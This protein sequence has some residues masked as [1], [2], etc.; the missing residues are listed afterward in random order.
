[1]AEVTGWRAVA[2]RLRES[3]GPAT[4]EQLTLAELLGVGLD[5]STPTPVAATTL[6]AALYQ[7][8]GEHTPRPVSEAQREYLAALAE[9]L[10]R[11]APKPENSLVASGWIEY[12]VVSGRIRALMS[13]RPEPGDTMR[14]AQ[15][16]NRVFELSSVG[17]EG[18]L[19]FRGRQL[20]WP[21]Q[22]VRLEG[23]GS[24]PR[25][26]Q[27][28][29]AARNQAA[30]TAPLTGPSVDGMAELRR[31]K[32][33]AAPDA[34][35]V[36]LLQGAVS[37][38]STEAPV[39]EVLTRYPGLLATAVLSKSHAQYVLPKLRLGGAY[40]T[41]F[42]VADADS[43]GLRWIFVELESPAAPVTLASQRDFSKAA[44]TGIAQIRE[45]R[46]WLQANMAM[47]RAKR[48]DQGLGLTGIRPGADGLVVVGRRHELKEQASSLRRSLAETERIHVR[49]YD[50]L[51]EQ[52]ARKPG[53]QPGTP[54]QRDDD[55]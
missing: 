6:R 49:T 39:Q 7:P 53:G 21:D 45:W 22:V 51:V 25:A 24:S 1:M 18:R 43:G 14:L 12:F 31:F 40:V 23:P 54:W 38:A 44:R 19:H 30:E 13:L 35:A 8:I 41:D 26:D 36:A 9:A 42:L 3:I 47:A 5:S 16:P 48:R 29:R 46:E 11:R 27:L 32:V 50:W 20:A 37:R 34:A 33:D 10:G 2:E 4:P 52:C 55:W 17:S 15:F 28:R